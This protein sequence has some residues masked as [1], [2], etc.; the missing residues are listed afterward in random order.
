MNHKFL[1][2]SLLCF[3]AVAAHAAAPEVKLV[4][5][6]TNIR[7]DRRP[8]PVGYYDDKADKT[9]VCWMSADSHPAIKAY[10]HSTGKWGKTKIVASS[11]LCRQA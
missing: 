10:D 5:E 9:F 7:S 6:R 3:G 2:T 1:L 8:I 4:E 11:P